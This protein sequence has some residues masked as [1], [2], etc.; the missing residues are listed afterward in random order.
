MHH[1]AEKGSALEI[2]SDNRVMERFKIIHAN[3]GTNFLKLNC[4]EHDHGTNFCLQTGTS[5]SHWN[6][7]LFLVDHSAALFNPSIRRK[8]SSSP[9]HRSSIRLSIKLIEIFNF[10]GPSPTGGTTYTA[11]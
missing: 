4:I 9:H 3:I 7:F 10:V 5:R 2:S 8:D 6:V 1:S 11:R